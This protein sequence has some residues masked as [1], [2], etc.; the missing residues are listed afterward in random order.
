MLETDESLG[1]LAEEAHLLYSVHEDSQAYNT[2]KA[3]VAGDLEEL[4]A[5][6]E[7]RRASWT[8]HVPDDWNGEVVEV[9]EERACLVVDLFTS[10]EGA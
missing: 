9:V 1:L 8:L 3:C 10:L 7:D 6:G 4:L 2:W 5:I